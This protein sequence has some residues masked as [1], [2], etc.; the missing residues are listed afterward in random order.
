MKEFLYF[1]ELLAFAIGSIGG[2]GFTLY[3]KAPW[4][5][6]LCVALLA[7]MAFP[8][9]SKAYNSLFKKNNGGA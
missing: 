3:N 6:V 8:Q 9:A 1:F 7:V 4:Y 2:F 5:I